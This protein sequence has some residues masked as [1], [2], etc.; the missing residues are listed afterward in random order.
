VAD[1][2]AYSCSVWEAA[3]QQTI[4]IVRGFLG[5]RRQPEEHF[6]TEVRARHRAAYLGKFYD[7]VI[8][9]QRVVESE[10]CGDRQ[11][12]GRVADLQT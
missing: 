5:G 3:M 4:Y 2:C 11:L 8:V 6:P 9:G 7:A 12:T 10:R 1:F